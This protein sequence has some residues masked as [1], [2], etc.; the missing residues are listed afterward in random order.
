MPRRT[1]GLSFAAV[2]VA[3]ASHYCRRLLVNTAA[4][5]VS[6]AAFEG[7]WCPPSRSVGGSGTACLRL[8]CTTTHSK[9]RH[10]TAPH[11]LAPVPVAFFPHGTSVP[12]HCTYTYTYTYTAALERFQRPC[13]T[14]PARACVGAKEC[15]GRVD[16][17]VAALLGRAQALA[18]K[19]KVQY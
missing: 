17:H 7:R 12:E 11:A 9:A 6:F 8:G 14:K 16:G 5:A 18:D 4:F 13:C 15:A 3:R 19:C 2:A 1:A 10:C